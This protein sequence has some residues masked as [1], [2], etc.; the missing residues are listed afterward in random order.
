V[1]ESPPPTSP[2]PASTPGPALVVGSPDPE[3][4]RW[5]PIVIIPTSA[6]VAYL[7]SS[8][9]G[10]KKTP[11]LVWDSMRLAVPIALLVLGLVLLRLTR[12]YF[13]CRSGTATFYEDRVAFR[14]RV[15]GQTRFTEATVAWSELGGYRDGSSDYI[16]LVRKGESFASPLLAIPTPSEDDRVKV[17]ALLDARGLARLNS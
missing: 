14:K 12:R 2:G 8:W 11:W 4:S 6:V 3:L 17:L 9:A 1:T 10:F 13:V 5:R 15:R 16:Q 7:I